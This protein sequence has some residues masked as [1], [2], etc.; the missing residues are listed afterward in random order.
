MIS[1]LCI[2]YLA[3][4]VAGRWNDDGA[5]EMSET[6]RDPLVVSV[7]RSELL[8]A[9]DPRELQTLT[10]DLK[11][12]ICITVSDSTGWYCSTCHDHNATHRT[13]SIDLGWVRVQEAM[14]SFNEALAVMQK[15]DTPWLF[16]I[17][18]AVASALSDTMNATASW[19]SPL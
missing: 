14:Q 8:D 9:D 12:P 15:G 2:A 6:L 13:M 3:W 19:L 17:M 18:N 5:V 4:P 7:S 10:C 16:G 1:L 11:R